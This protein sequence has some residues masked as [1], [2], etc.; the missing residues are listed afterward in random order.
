MSYPKKV[1]I[2]EVGPRDG[3]QNEPVWIATE[4]K[5][6]WINQLSRTGLSYIEITSFVHPKWIPALR[7]ATDVAKGIDRE[8]GVTYA[9]LVPNQRGL[10]NAL[11]GGIDEACVFMSASETHNRK[12]INK[13]TSE[14][15]HILK[16]VNNDAQKANLTTRAYLSTV[17]GCP[18]E[19]DVPIEQV[20]RLSEALFEFGISELSLGDTIGAANPAQVETVLEALLARFPANQIALHFHDTRGTALANMVTALQMGITVFDGSAGGLGGCPYAP[21]SS[22]NAATED[23]V[24]MLEQM[25]I[26]TNVKLEK[27]LSAAKW[28]EEK[29]GKPLPSRNLQVFKS[30]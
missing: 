11:E 18:Y 4:D 9:A 30:S 2:K 19:K 15:L 28:I 10:E 12:N 25:D 21:G 1:T 13:S 22:G 8:K 24:Y 17:F 27:L 29:M 16:Q 26:K 14:S 23:I 3:L 6:I 5:I 20:I 7:D